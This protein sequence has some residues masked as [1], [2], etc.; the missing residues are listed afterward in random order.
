[1]GEHYRIIHLSDIHVGQEI[2]GSQR[3]HAD[4]RGELLRDVRRLREQLGA[5]DTIIVTGDT[6]FSGTR[7]EYEE[8]GNWLG[9]LCQTA[10]CPEESV[11]VIPGNHD[12]DW[13]KITPA[14]SDLQRTVRDA[15]SNIDHQI[16]SRFHQDEMAAQMLLAKFGN[17]RE[18]ANRYGSDFESCEQPYWTYDIS[19][20]DSSVIRLV[21]L[22]TAL[23]SDRSEDLGRIVLGQNQYIWSREDNVECIVLMHHPPTWL[24]DSANARRYLSS[25]AKVWLMGHEHD[26]RIEKVESGNLEYLKVHAGATNPPA[27]DGYEFRYN[28]LTFSIYTSNGIRQMIVTVWPRVWTTSGTGFVPDRNL[29]SGRE[30]ADYRLTLS[31]IVPSVGIEEL[32]KASLQTELTRVNDTADRDIGLDRRGI[33]GSMENDAF[34]R[35]QYLFW[36]KLDQHQRLQLL[37]ELHVLPELG[38]VLSSVWLRRG[39]E[40]AKNQGLLYELWDNLM[41]ML[42]EDQQEPNPFLPLEED[43]T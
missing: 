33:I 12:V 1:M 7:S 3:L 4:V 23:F 21:G 35:L 11:F 18:F 30:S 25:R 32:E 39:L 20:L 28:W 38:P 29:I 24:R 40:T 14:V 9:N 22:N 36:K 2:V 10:G 19:V 41:K 8:A 17:Y 26:L 5:A 34:R 6:A 42:P 13:T 15:N 43:A 37:I 31:S 16:S 27:Q